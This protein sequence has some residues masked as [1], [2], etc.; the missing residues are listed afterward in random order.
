MRVALIS[1]IHGN[2]FA[3]AAVLEDI[4]RRKVDATYNLG[5]H[6]SGPIAPAETAEMLLGLDAVSL[7]GNHDRVVMAG[8]NMDKVDVIA[9]AAID[10]SARSWLGTL[11]ETA[12]PEPDILLCHGTPSSDNTHWLQTKTQ[13]KRFRPSSTAEIAQQVS[14]H[15]HA[16]LCCGHSHVARVVELGD[17]RI[18]VNPGS[19]G[20]P[21]YTMADPASAERLSPDAGYAIATRT[22]SGWS[23]TL[24][25]I[26]YDHEAAALR[27][28]QHGMAGWARH[29]R[30]GWPR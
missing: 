23:A 27:A 25:Q 18:V 26:P 14:G 20:R 24:L 13:D 11:A 12:S 3:L 29:L 15:T 4:A 17:G 7:R 16:L 1:D 19:V 9:A 30:E 22:R 21:A 6:V 10:D 8:E 5:D 28:E 2:A